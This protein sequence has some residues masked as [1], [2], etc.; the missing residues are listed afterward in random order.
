MAEQVAKMTEK[1]AVHTAAKQPRKGGVSQVLRLL[2]NANH[3]QSHKQQLSWVKEETGQAPE[4]RWKQTEG[5]R[6][7]G[8]ES[9][10]RERESGRKPEKKLR[11][12]VPGTDPESC[13]AFRAKSLSH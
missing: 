8:V 9:G 1:K 3:R 6:G 7:W 12:V 10:E 5:K 2:H 4:E 13:Q 11:A